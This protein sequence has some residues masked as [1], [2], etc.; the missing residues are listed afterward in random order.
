[1]SEQLNSSGIPKIEG[2]FQHKTK[3]GMTLHCIVMEK[4]D[5]DTLEQWLQK[6][7]NQPINDKL[8]IAWL[9]EIVNILSLVP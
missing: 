5:G 2:Y 8:A 4:I 3:A 7:R 1:M 9:E 6:N